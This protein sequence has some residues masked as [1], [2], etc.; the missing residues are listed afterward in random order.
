[1]NR[2]ASK[3]H[4]KETA[5]LY[6][7]AHRPDN[8]GPR[9]FCWAIE[10]E[11]VLPPTTICGSPAGADHCGC[12]RSFA[13]MSSH[14][15]TT[16]LMV[17][18]LDLTEADLVAAALGSANAAGWTDDIDGDAEDQEYARGMVAHFANIAACYPPGTVLRPWYDH[19]TEEWYFRDCT[20]YA[21]VDD[22][23]AQ[24]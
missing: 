16:T 22:D 10:G 2:P 12:N 18:E 8:L 3:H 14:K 24:P 11:P 1:V 4:T 9:D 6:L 7:T 19:D 13:G 5:M 17:R 21:D 20:H 15:A 23:G